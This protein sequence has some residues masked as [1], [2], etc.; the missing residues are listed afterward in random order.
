MNSLH[1]FYYTESIN[2]LVDQDRHLI[3]KHQIL[4]LIKLN[5]A[6]LYEILIDANN[7]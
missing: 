6:T 4:F 1:S 7:I 3:K 2:S 5:S